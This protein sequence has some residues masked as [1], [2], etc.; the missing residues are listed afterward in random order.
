MKV[1]W[2]T[3]PKQLTGGKRKQKGGSSE[4]IPTDVLLDLFPP[5]GYASVQNVI[6]NHSGVPIK[7]RD[8]KK[9]LS[10]SDLDENLAYNE[11]HFNLFGDYL[12]DHVNQSRLHN[13]DDA[14]RLTGVK[15]PAMYYEDPKD[16]TKEKI[17]PFHVPL[18]YI[19]PEIAGKHLT[20]ELLKEMEGNPLLKLYVVD[21]L[22]EKT[23]EGYTKPL[24]GVVEDAKRQAM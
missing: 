23:Y 18:P 4:F 5:K 2:P 17:A 19:P 12:V 20:P 1:K 14:L 24:F 22:K 11:L 3:D 10:L 13:M 15:G 9:R 21:L 16:S 7:V 8:S 6:V